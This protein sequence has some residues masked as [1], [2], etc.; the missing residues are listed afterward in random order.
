MSVPTKTT[1]SNETS[2]QFQALFVATR[3]EFFKSRRNIYLPCL[4]QQNMDILNV[5]LR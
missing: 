4:G 3:P 5:L 1:I 2:G